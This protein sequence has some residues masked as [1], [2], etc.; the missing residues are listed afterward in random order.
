M[1]N[2]LKVNWEKNLTYESDDNIK[3]MREQDLIL[4]I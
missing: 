1:N 3:K 4:K 2:E